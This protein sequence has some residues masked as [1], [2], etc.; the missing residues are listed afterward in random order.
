MEAQGFQDAQKDTHMYGI[1]LEKGGGNN[2]YTTSFRIFKVWFKY[3]SKNA[4]EDG[5]CDPRS[6]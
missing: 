4:V 6:A 5:V 1:A 3:S 2:Q